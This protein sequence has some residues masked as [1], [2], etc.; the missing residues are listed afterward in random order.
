VTFEQRFAGP[1]TAEKLYFYREWLR[2]DASLT[3]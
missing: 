1:L 3:P 2:P